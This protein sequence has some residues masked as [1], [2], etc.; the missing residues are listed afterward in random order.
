M[1]GDHGFSIVDVSDPS[2]PVF[3]G[4]YD[5]EYSFDIAVSGDYAYVASISGLSIVDVSGPSSPVLT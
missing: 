1:A 2:S 5:T 4:Q 3:M